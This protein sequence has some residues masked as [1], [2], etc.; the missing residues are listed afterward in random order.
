M[1]IWFITRSYPPLKGGGPQMRKLQVDFL[2]KKYAVK[3]ITINHDSN[4]IH[5]KNEVTFIPYTRNKYLKK[6]NVLL[7]MFGIIKDSHQ[8]WI[9]R[10][11]SYLKDKIQNG[12]I[13]FSTTGGELASILIGCELKRLNKDI[14]YIVNYHDLLDYGYYNGERIY[15]RFHVNIDK[16]EEK[17][18]M[19]ADFI[20]SNSNIMRDI[21]IKKFDFTKNKTDKLYFG[22]KK[23]SNINRKLLSNENKIKIANIG[24][25]SHLQSP[26]ILIDAYNLLPNSIRNKIELVFIGDLNFNNKIKNSDIIT[27]DYIDRDKLVPFVLDN[28][29]YAFLSLININLFKPAMPTK[30][31]EY[32]GLELPIIGALPENSEATKVIKDYNFGYACVHGDIESLKNILISIC[33]DDE[34][35]KYLEF[36]NN[37][38]FNKNIFDSEQTLKGMYNMI[39][40]LNEN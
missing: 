25:A 4:K 30:F 15:Q 35:K 9:D 33:E 24:S 20:F 7:E 37:L 26:E 40:L 2:R 28:I 14:K 21:I 23:V 18:L 31:Y 34:R 10:T 36:R 6:L 39:D 8:T 29:D 1:K 11:V 12:D 22:Y 19:E 32:I 38:I 17:C 5:K 16:L 3:V 27:I 13:V